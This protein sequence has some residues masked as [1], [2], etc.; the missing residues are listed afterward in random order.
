MKTTGIVLCG[1]LSTRMGRAK[2]WLP[3]Q[4]QPMLVHVA[5]RLAGAVGDLVVVAAAEQPLPSVDARVVRDEHDAL[6]P[7]AGLVAGLSAVEEGLAFVTATDAPFLSAAFV[8]QLLGQGRPAAP[9]ID[10]FVQ[11]LS[12]VY[13]ADAHSRARELVEAGRRRPRDLLEA[14]D[15]L[16]LTASELPDVD[17]V[18]GFNTPA[19]YLDAL[20]EAGSEPVRLDLAPMGLGGEGRFVSAAPGRLGAV[21]EACPAT[22]PIVA[23]G[24]LEAGHHVRLVSG[25]TVRGLD[26]PLGP[27]ETVEVVS[28]GGGTP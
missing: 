24:E 21:L 6:G 12:A 18:R 25:E 2:A 22:R 27:G 8:R 16:A 7:L 10:G 13:P 14:V 3:W 15:Y 9:V 17:S 23:S 11:A 5:E 19:A 20:G 28:P 1:G 26:V 4:G